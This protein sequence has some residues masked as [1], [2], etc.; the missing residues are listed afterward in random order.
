MSLSKYYSTYS[1]LLSNTL[2]LQLE[3]ILKALIVKV[4]D[5]AHNGI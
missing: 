3:L 4:T 2:L 1:I 5:I